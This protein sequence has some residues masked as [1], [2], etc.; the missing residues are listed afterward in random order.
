MCG[1][2]G[3]GQHYPIDE[4]GVWADAFHQRSPVIHNDYASLAHKKGLPEGHAPITRELVVPIIREG[5]VTEIMGV[6]NKA[7][8]Y[9]Q[10]DVDVAVMI[11][12]MVQD[13]IDRKRAEDA[14][15]NERELLRQI[16]MSSPVGI[17]VVHRSG[18]IVMANTAAETV[19]GVKMD[20][21]AQRNYDS[22]VWKHTDL[23]GDVFP[24]DQLPVARVL[25]TG[26]PVFDVENG[27]E[28]PD[29]HRV[30]LSVNA[31]PLMGASGAVDRVVATITDITEHKQAEI[32]RAS[33][34]TQLRESQKMEAIGTLAGG[35]AHDFNNI[36]ATILGNAELAFQ[37]AVTNPRA[38]Q[39]SVNE[40]RKAGRRARSLVQQILS[41]SRRQSTERE[42]I[43]VAA[44]VLE[45]A[46]LLR[47]IL[48][49]RLALD[50]DCEPAVPPVLADATQ[51]EQVMINLATNAMQAMPSGPGRISIRL[52]TAMV[53]A[54]LAETHP[55]LRGLHARHPGRTVRIAVSDTGQGMEA[56]TLERI[57][58]PFFTTK[59]VNEG[60]GLG[61]S[62]VHGIVQGHEGA[63]TVESRLGKG[64]CFTLYLPVAEGEAGA[65]ERGASA[66]ASAPELSLAGGLRVLYLDDDEALVFLVKRL[67]ERRG[68]R[69][70]GYTNQR[71][72]LNALR[73]DAAA[74]DLVLTDYNMPGASGLDVAREVRTI[75]ADLPVAVASGFVDEELR[76]QAAAAGVV[77]LIYKADAVDDYCE[78]IQRLLQPT[79]AKSK[80]S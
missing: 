22:P 64:T 10:D 6:G 69:V 47:A 65:P 15:R 53:D 54:A 24:V 66:A 63:I 38:A 13:I 43:D 29:G 4:A 32:T 2:E 41:F 78:V 45:S 74:F 23:A 25:A 8:N 17:V 52:D 35:V 1:A 39:E 27:I 76:A 9:V 70:S 75:R 40:I 80:T 42:R 77:E 3:Q 44:V 30:L 55:S 14:L 73:A 79:G 72:A 58:E 67:L 57:F 33:L 34:E 37:D 16:T 46:R 20:E 36:I 61:L 11:A 19:L 18:Q 21:L 7:T 71:E 59:A 49:A 60:T 28:W 5:K 62:V 68:Y 48:P 50:V 56:A 51:I 26:A 31:A 12:A